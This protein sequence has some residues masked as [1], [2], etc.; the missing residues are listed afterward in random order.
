[1]KRALEVLGWLLA[2]ALFAFAGRAVLAAPAAR[3]GVP[4]RLTAREQRGARELA[5][6]FAER[7][8]MSDD[9]APLVEEMFVA[10]FG[11]RLR[12]APGETPMVFVAPE[13]LARAEPEA[14]RRFYTAEFNYLSLV[15]QHFAV[16][17]QELEESGREEGDL[18]TE[19]I[20][21]PSVLF[22][23]RGDP[24]Y[25]QMLSSE[26]RQRACEEAAQ[27]RPG[28]AVAECQGDTDEAFVK[29]L[30]DLRDT[31]AS[32]E[33]VTAALR[34]YVPTMLRRWEMQ[35]GRAA[36]E[37]FVEVR[38]PYLEASDAEKY[39]FPPGTRFAR[40]CVEPIEG[41]A[42]DLLMVEVEGAM[43]LVSAFPVFG[44]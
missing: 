10:D 23:L 22:V 2:L 6:R 8:R 41:I 20:F 9:L 21:P 13:V 37:E 31:T 18:T 33:R 30:E 40:V 28:V 16:R 26:E 25:L 3:Q 32:A 43:R 34:P 1:M 19:E 44:D 27:E 14:L 7:L 4:E 17:Q 39:G 15:V 36:G 5:A 38:E 24:L 12:R 11:E 35:R 42:F 29:S